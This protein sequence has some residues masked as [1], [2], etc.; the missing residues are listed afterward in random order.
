M[1][2]LQQNRVSISGVVSKKYETRI[3]PAGI[4]ISRLILEHQSKQ[5]EAGLSREIKCRVLVII[6]GKELNDKLVNLVIGN[7]ITV[8]GFL[9]NSGNP[10]FDSSLCIN[11]IEIDC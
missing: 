3:T 10:G 6:T 2:E 8:G 7:Q 5:T 9:S 1:P 11:A 4:P